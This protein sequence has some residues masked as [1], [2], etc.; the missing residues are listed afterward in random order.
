VGLEAL[1]AEEEAQVGQVMTEM[2]AQ[3]A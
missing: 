3:V 2:V 1:L